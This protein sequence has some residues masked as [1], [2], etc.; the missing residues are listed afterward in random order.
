MSPFTGDIYTELH[1]CSGYGIIDG[2]HEKKKKK[3]EK[4]P[5]SLKGRNK[6]KKKKETWI[7]SLSYPEQQILFL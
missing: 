7:K 3:K 5:W 6:C 4:K 2:Q 1:L